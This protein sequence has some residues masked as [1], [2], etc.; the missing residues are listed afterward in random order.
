MRK[1]TLHTFN[2]VKSGDLVVDYLRRENVE[3]DHLK[4]LQFV[5]HIMEK[6][7]FIGSMKKMTHKRIEYTLEDAEDY[8]DMLL[9]MQKITDDLL[10]ESSDV[11]LSRIEVEVERA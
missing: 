7:A 5:F 2:Q 6:P 8:S 11:L 4:S 1:V 9:A 3:D 10:H